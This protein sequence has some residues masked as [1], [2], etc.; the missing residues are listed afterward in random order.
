MAGEGRLFMFH[1][2]FNRKG[3]AVRRESERPGSYILPVMIRNKRR[4]LVMSPSGPSDPRARNPR[5][6]AGCRYWLWLNDATAIGTGETFTT[7]DQVRAY[8]SKLKPRL[9]PKPGG[10][11]VFVREGRATWRSSKASHRVAV[12][13]PV[14]AEKNARRSPAKKMSGR[15]VSGATVQLTHS[16]L[17]LIVATLRTSAA[18]LKPGA[19]L[20]AQ[21]IGLQK[22][23]YDTLKELPESNPAVLVVGA[24]PGGRRQAE[25]RIFGKEVER[26]TYRHVTQG[27]RFHDFGPG[28][29]LEALA[30]G[31][32]RI[33]NPSR[34]LWIED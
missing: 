9:H 2:A 20:R 1:G 10:D 23:L 12:E 33:F 30:D 6:I 11:V 16:D 14:G 19:P 5:G 18:M 32:V 3:D 34:P 22:T 24:N 25:G 17:E 31:S 13:L 26:L 7:M 21:L 29:R 28:A 15:N 8:V 4:F 27:R